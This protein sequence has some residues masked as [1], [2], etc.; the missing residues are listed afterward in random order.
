MH[1]R[2]AHFDYAP[3]HTLLLLTKV[4]VTVTAVYKLQHA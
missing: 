1:H 4:C 3:A 2:L